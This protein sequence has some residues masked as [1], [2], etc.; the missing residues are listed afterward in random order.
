MNGRSLAGVARKAGIASIVYTIPMR[1]IGEPD[2]IAK[3]ALFLASDD[4]SFV[5]G[6]EL[7]ADGGTAQI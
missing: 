3:R 6:I 4:F 1:R 7:L 2:E 5:T